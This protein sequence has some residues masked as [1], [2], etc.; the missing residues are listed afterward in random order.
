MEKKIL[1]FCGGYEGH[2]PFKIMD[3]LSRRLQSH[4][5][6]AD[7]SDSLECLLDPDLKHKYN[8]I[9]PAWTMG[10]MDISSPESIAFCSAVRSGVALAGWHGCMGDS[11]RT[12]VHFQF[13][14]GG[15]FICHPGI[16]RD[17]FRVEYTVDIQS[18]EHPIV[19]GIDNFK[20]K[21]EQYYMHCAPGNNV[22]ATTT[23][24]GAFF[25]WIAGQI[26]P[27]VWTKTY[28][29]GRVFYSSLGHSFSD[30]EDFPQIAEITLRGFL[31]ALG[32]YDTEE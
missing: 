5:V 2:E 13:M 23:F 10:D 12:N 7:I 22:I 18:K 17:G 11:F 19:R 1:A 32:K 24:D 21:S 26:M 4:G 30:F 31:W 25:P 3:F 20:V 9:V 15:Q 14:V 27:A 29:A 6:S 16:Y 28:G 8:M